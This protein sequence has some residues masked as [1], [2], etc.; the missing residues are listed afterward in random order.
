MSSTGTLTLQQKRA[1][2]VLGFLYLRMGQDV[3]ARRLFAALVAID[4]DDLLARCSLAQACL[5]LGDGETALH[6]LAGLAKGDPLPG[7]DATLSLLL[8]KSYQLLDDQQAAREA[9]ADYFK[10]RRSGGEK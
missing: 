5:R 6:T 8:A 7:G 9:L 4:P 1:L 10:L 3:R 2:S